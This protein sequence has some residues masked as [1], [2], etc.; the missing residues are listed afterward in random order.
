MWMGFGVG[1]RREGAVG[2]SPEAE[3]RIRRRTLAVSFDP[4]PAVSCARKRCDL[5][6]K[7]E[8][9]LAGRAD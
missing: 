5:Q 8:S 2:L 4:P 9:G 1:G 3:K 6:V 7:R